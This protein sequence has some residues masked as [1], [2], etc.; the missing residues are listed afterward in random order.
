MYILFFFF[1]FNMWARG[2]I[3]IVIATT[4]RLLHIP[5]TFIIMCIVIYGNHRIPNDIP[6]SVHFEP[7]K[8][9]VVDSG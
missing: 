5:P 9:N 4:F 7:N 8:V 1:L 3:L 6:Y 2:L